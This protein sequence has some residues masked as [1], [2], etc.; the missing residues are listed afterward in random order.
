[1]NYYTMI[2]QAL[3][4]IKKVVLGKEDIIK[5]I[6]MAFFSKGHV[7]IEDIPGVGKTTLALAFSK[8]MDLKVNRLQFTFDVL[9][10]DITGFNMYDQ[11]KKQFVL[12]EGPI[13][14]NLFL[15]D[16]INR[17]SPKTQSALLEVMEENGVT[18]DGIRYQVPSPFCVIATQNPIGSSGTQLLPE[19]QIDRFMIS[20]ELGYPDTESEVQMLKDRHHYNP[21]DSLKLVFTQKQVVE[22]QEVVENI[23]IHDDIY[24]YIAS[25]A[26]Q[27]RNNENI[28]VGMSPRGSIALSKMA[29]AQA[30][31]NHRDYV[32]PKDIEEV[33]FNVVAHRVIISNKAKINKRSIQDIIVE[34]LTTTKKPTIGE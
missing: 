31:M 9:P 29:K 27:T 12:H 10:S 13:I 17:T 16:E 32:I 30:L 8:V 6:M 23:F 26:K 1:M 20:I 5:K 19:S 28:E 2:D 24:Q 21:L 22:I 3:N 11:E 33:F 7:L 34:I 18:I 15:A 14:C 4:E 25:L